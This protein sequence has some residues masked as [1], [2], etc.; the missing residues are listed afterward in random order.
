MLCNN[1]TNLAKL[2]IVS[3]PLPVHVS[4]PFRSSCNDINPLKGASSSKY[5]LISLASSLL[6]S[7]FN[8]HSANFV[9]CTTYFD[10]NTVILLHSLANFANG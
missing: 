5:K 2:I 1:S 6:G 8:F 10:A 7:L 9:P 4:S 3:S